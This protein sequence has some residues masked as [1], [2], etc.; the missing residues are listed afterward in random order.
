MTATWV[1]EIPWLRQ[2]TN[3]AG[4]F[5]GGWQ[6]SGVASIQDGKPFTVSSGRDNSLQGAQ[7]QLNT[8]RPDLLGDPHLSTERP[9]A[10]VLDRDFDVTQFAQNQ[11]G[12]FGNAGRNILIGPGLITFDLSLR[13]RFAVR[14]RKSVD[15]VWQ[16]FN[17]LNRANFGQPQSVLSS[18]ASLGRITSAG[19]GRVMQLALRFEF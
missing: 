19:A 10:Q 16:A 13:K 5:V 8:D 9:K 4:R 17:A 12:Q 14:E 3:L 18:G 15:F 7:T 11:P 2:Q 6:F 1:W